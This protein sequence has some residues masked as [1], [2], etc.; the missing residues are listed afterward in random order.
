[1]SEIYFLFL[2]KEHLSLLKLH[3]WTRSNLNLLVA[4]ELISY[5][6]L[7]SFLKGAIICLCFLTT[8]CWFFKLHSPIRVETRT[9]ACTSCTCTTRCCFDCYASPKKNKNVM[10]NANFCRVAYTTYILSH[11]SNSEKLLHPH[12]IQELLTIDPLVFLSPV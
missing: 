11:V 4:R 12:G 6:F 8:L 3:L 7:P 9:C 10:Q 1:M 2:N 5:F